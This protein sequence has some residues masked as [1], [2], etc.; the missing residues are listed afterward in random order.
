MRLVAADAGDVATLLATFGVDEIAGWEERCCGRRGAEDDVARADVLFEQALV[1]GV[2]G[3]EN[4]LLCAGVVFGADGVDVVWV[5][6]DWVVEAHEAVAGRV[7]GAGDDVE[8]VDL[9]A[10]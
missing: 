5:V 2:R 6:G 3:G 7:E 8:V 9:V 10:A 4:G 1:L